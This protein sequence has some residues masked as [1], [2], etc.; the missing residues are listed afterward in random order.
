MLDCMDDLSAVRYLSTCSVLHAGYHEYPVKQA[1]SVA[2]HLDAYFDRVK[3]GRRTVEQL[4]AVILFC[5]LVLTFIAWNEFIAHVL[6]IACNALIAIDIGFLVWLP[7]S[8]RVDCCK[9]DWWA[10]WRRRYIIPRV[11][12]L[13]DELSDMRL[14][15]H[16]QHLTELTMT[17]GEFKLCRREYRLPRSLRTLRLKDSPSL[18]LRSDTLPPHL[19]SLSLG[20]VVDKPFPAGV[21]PQSLTSLHLTL[22]FNARSRRLLRACCPP[23]CSS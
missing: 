9:R 17:F 1:M 19:T 13:S 6:I 21:L 23:A 11:Q 3:R 20:A 10:T 16:L 18:T 2:T 4:Q 22:G 14:L 12:Q 7:L 8:R 5:T 15:P